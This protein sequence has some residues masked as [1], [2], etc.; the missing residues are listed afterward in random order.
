ML[1]ARELAATVAVSAVLGLSSCGLHR[2]GQEEGE[3]AESRETL[4]LVDNG[5]WANVTV[6]VMRGNARVRVGTV[7]TMSSREF[8][9]PAIIVRSVVNLR[10]VADPVGAEPYVSDAVLVGPGDLIEFRITNVLAH[11]S[12]SV[13]Q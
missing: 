6:Y 1:F 7:T 5:H 11:S 4:L 9:V 8:V 3:E 10:L 2:G 12:I 13:W